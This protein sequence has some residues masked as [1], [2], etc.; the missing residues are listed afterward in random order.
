MLTVVVSGPVSDEARRDLAA[1][2]ATVQF[3]MAS[4]SD[5]QRSIDRAYDALSGIDQMVAGVN[6]NNAAIA[7]P[8]SNVSDDQ[9]PIVQAV[10]RILTQA[11]RERASDV[12]IEPQ[13][14]CLRVRFRVDGALHDAGRLPAGIAQP[15]VSRLKILAD[16]NIVE[17]RRAQD[18]QF[19]VT[20][21]GR[22]LDVRVATTATIWGE[23]AVLRLLDKSRS[24]LQLPRLGM[25]ADTRAEFSTLVR[26]PVRHGDL[27]RSHRKRQDD[28]AL[29]GAEPDQRPERNVTTIEDPVEYVF[30]SINQMQINEQA[31]ITF[32]GGLKAI[33][34]QDPDIILVGEMRDVETARIAVQSALTGHFVLS[35]STRPTPRPRC[36]DSSTWG[37]SRS[38]SRRRSSAFS[39]NASCAESATGA[40][41]PTSRP[42]TTRVLRGVGRQAQDDFRTA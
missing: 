15:L 23:K 26:V 36:T 3:V 29:R 28:H 40:G 19:A 38:W 2:G 14:D 24:L 31:D 22:Q 17:R 42:Q 33:L 32:E 12:H 37:S 9:A 8:G 39:R 11:V 30:P 41:N 13:D 35:L 4:V 16:M 27:R 18:G 20:V 21:D 7:T 10:Q 1:S 5:V 6:F 34:R 25:T